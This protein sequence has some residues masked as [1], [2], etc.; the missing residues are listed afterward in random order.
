[1]ADTPERAAYKREWE[2]LHDRRPCPICSA[3]M[4]AGAHRKGYPRC[5][6]CREDENTTA[7]TRIQQLHNTGLNN[8]EVGMRVGKSPAA[9]ANAL[10]KMRKLGIVIAPTRYGQR[11]KEN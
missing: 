10:C 1:M 11:T 8:I 5:A 2:D 4:G 7:R 3:L 9:V 6:A